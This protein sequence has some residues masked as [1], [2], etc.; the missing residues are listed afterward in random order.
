MC[1]VMRKI[2]EKEWGRVRCPHHSCVNEG[3][4][5]ISEYKSCVKSTGSRTSLYKRFSV[6]ESLLV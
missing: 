1:I 4:E 6:L 5:T 2:P 3:T